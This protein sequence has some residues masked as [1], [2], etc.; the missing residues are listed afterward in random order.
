M[1]MTETNVSDKG[2]A[3]LLGITRD[4]LGRLRHSPLMEHKNNHG[5]ILEYYL[6]ISPTNDP[7][8]LEKIQIES[9][10]FIRFTVRQINAIRNK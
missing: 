6:H 9:S 4:E 7:A 2:L 1:S 10:N 8:L 3:K 5:D